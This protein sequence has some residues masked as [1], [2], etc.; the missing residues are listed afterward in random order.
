MLK[1]VSAFVA[2]TA[3]FVSAPA[4]ATPPSANFSLFYIQNSTAS[5][6]GNPA[7]CVFLAH[8]ALVQNGFTNIGSDSVEAWGDNG[9]TFVVVG[10]VPWG[11][12]SQWAGAHVVAAGPDYTATENWR[13]TIRAHMLN[14]KW[15]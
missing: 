10:C 9:D 1:L 12:G 7:F 8:D 13:N 2:L 6:M 11:S 14:A 3:I 5:G 4:R 15:F